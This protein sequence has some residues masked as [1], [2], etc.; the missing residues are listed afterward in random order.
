MEEN[1]DGDDDGCRGDG[2]GCGCGC[3]WDRMGLET[4]SS[5]RSCYDTVAASGTLRMAAEA[6]VGVETLCTWVCA[7]CV[8]RGAGETTRRQEC[9]GESEKVRIILLE[10]TT[11]KSNE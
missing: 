3:A 10:K 6:A 11:K 7:W 1:G 8:V 5:G 2:A 9:G 4:S